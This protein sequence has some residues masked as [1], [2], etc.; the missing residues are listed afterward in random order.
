MFNAKSRMSLFKSELFLSLYFSWFVST[1]LCKNLHNKSEKLS[2]EYGAA[3]KPQ[4]PSQDVGLVSA[5][6]SVPYECPL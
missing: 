1:M 3:R 6:I 4:N 2:H 5:L